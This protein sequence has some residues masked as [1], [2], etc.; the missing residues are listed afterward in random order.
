MFNEDTLREEIVAK[1]GEHGAH[2]DVYD[3]LVRLARLAVA[4]GHHPFKEE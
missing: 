1:W 2:I 3:N 4:D